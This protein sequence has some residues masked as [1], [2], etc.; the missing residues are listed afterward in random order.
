MH[1]VSLA[2]L[3]AR[4]SYTRHDL[5]SMAVGQCSL[6]G[7]CSPLGYQQVLLCLVPIVPQA[8]CPRTPHGLPKVEGPIHPGVDAHKG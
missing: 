4:A 3:A 5:D 2:D 8:D 7:V 1:Q 6:G